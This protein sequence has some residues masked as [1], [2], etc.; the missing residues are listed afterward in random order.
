MVRTSLNKNEIVNLSVN[1]T[2]LQ[3]L[4]AEKK[5]ATGQTNNGDLYVNLSITSNY[6]GEEKFGHYN[7]VTIAQTKE[8]R[9][10]KKPKEFIGSADV[11]KF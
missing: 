2:K 10:A 11:L 7:Q 5:I 8:E 4:I 6:K 3:K 1:L 9:D